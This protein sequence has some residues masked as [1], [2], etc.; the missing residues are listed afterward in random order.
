MLITLQ[1][2]TAHLRIDDDTPDAAALLLKVDAAGL[3]AAEY[4]GRQLFVDQAALDAAVLDGTAGQQPMVVNSLV[5]AAILLI[6][7]HLYAHREDVITGS[8][9]TELDMGSRSLLAP[10]RVGMG[11]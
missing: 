3:L 11:I 4:L 9:S 5:R 8:I 1:Q 7:G 6:L 2:A 10:F